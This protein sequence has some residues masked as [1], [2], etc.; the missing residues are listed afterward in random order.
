MRLLNFVLASATLARLWRD[1]DVLDIPLG[2]CEAIQGDLAAQGSWGTLLESA[3]PARWPA[4]TSC[5]AIRI[6]QQPPWLR[7]GM[8]RR[9]SGSTASGAWRQRA[10]ARFAASC[11]ETGPSLELY[12]LAIDLLGTV[13]WRGIDRRDQERLLTRYAEL[14]S[15]AAAIAVTAGQPELAVEFLERGRG[16]LLGRLL[17]DNADITRLSLINPGQADRLAALLRDLDGIIMP[18]PEAAEFSFVQRPPEQASEADQRS[19][20]ARQ[21][22]SLI[23]EIRAQPGCGDLFTPPRFVDLHA[24]I[25]SKSVAVINISTYR[26]DAIITTPGGMQAI[27]L[28]VLTRH[29]ADDAARFFRTRAEDAA[30][31]G[32]SGEAARRALTTRLAWLWETVAGPVLQEAGMTST[33]PAATGVPRLYWCP[34]GPA[35]FLPLHAAGHHQPTGTSAPLTVIAPRRIGLH[36]Q[37]PHAGTHHAEATASHKIGPAPLI[38]SMPTTPGMP[39]LPT[40]Q[41]EGDR[42]ASIFPDALLLSGSAATRDAVTTQMGTHRW[43]HFAVHGITDNDTPV[44]GG[45]ELTDGRLTIRDL[46]QLR[47][48]R[49]QFGYLSA[50]K[51]YQSTPAIPDEAVTVATALHIVG[52][53]TVAAALWQ[54]ADDHA[55]DFAHRMYDR[56]ITCQGADPPPPL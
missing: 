30:Q 29:D 4:D 11:N 49:A 48:P 36:P 45:L 8:G 42:L 25:G 39:P 40:A 14:P 44:N 50:C 1:P 26:C 55:A 52:C 46:L 47:L 37:A 16:V 17:D 32:E 2:M 12:A 43:Y 7:T 56:L 34:T 51:T 9:T 24:A 6:R 31:P 53:Q 18:D 23:E 3:T 22:D 13:I 33:A 35:V 20:L 28:R 15:D 54:V 27:P 10:P 19:A 38:V 21:V 5:P 41:A